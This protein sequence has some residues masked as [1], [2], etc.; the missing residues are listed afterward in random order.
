LAADSA[1]DC[2][3]GPGDGS[4][5]A[6]QNRAN[7]WKSRGEVDALDK[8]RCIVLPVHRQPGILPQINVSECVVLAKTRSSSPKD[9]AQDDAENGAQD[10]PSHVVCSLSMFA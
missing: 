7:R 10:N 4:D 6:S 3:R 5:N 9:G 8:L 1:D 2:G